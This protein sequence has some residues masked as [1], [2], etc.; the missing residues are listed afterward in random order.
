M[1]N[2]WPG[3]IIRK[4]PVTPSGGTA[5]GVW[6]LADAAYWKK[7]GLW[8]TVPGAPTI[9][10]ATV[11]S[12]TSVSVP[13]TAPADAGIPAVITGYTVTSSPGGITATG[14]SSPITVT[15]L[16]T[17]TAY[18]FTVRATNA[19]GTGPASAA[20]NSVTPTAVT[21]QIV[22]EGPV[23]GSFTSYSFVVPAGVTSISVVN[24]AAGGRSSEGSGN[25]AYGNNIT[26][27]PGETLTVFAP[28]GNSVA[29]SVESA[30]LSRGGTNLVVAGSRQAANSGTNLSGGGAGRTGAG[31]G[32]GGYSGQ[33]GKGDNYGG[34]AGNAGVGGAGGGGGGRATYSASPPPYDYA[35]S[36]GGGGGGGVG[37]LGQ[38]SNGVGGSAGVSGFTTTGG[39]GGGAGSGGSNGAA[40]GNAD[41]TNG[42]NAGNG[43]VYGASAGE[44]GYTFT[45]T[46]G[47][48]TY[49]AYGLGAAGARGA[50]RIIWPGNTRQFPST[51][52]G[53]L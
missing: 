12:A 19:A 39:G 47:S 51:N 40:G 53:D 27:T 29:S 30:R 6:S 28:G 13:F 48:L 11:P 7:Q 49:V 26:V 44:P 20:S 34:A 2:R 50:V 23:N 10:T 24:V 38:G 41:T 21:G 8:P 4:T 17:G 35:W 18:T 37:L 33:G 32:A 46:S 22:Y 5:S 16:T 15:G 9:G 1:S 25:L 42:G 45:Y 14:S 3:G 43:G 36:A 52:T 31:S